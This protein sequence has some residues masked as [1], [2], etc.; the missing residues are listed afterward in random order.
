MTE[1]AHPPVA[2]NGQPPAT[3]A[4]LD[5][6]S[7]SSGYLPIAEHGV[8]GDLHSAA[9]VGTDGTIDWYCPERFDRPSVF[10]AL[11]DRRSGGFYRIAPTDPQIVAKQLYLPDTAVLI[12]RFL[13]PAGVSEIQDFMPVDGTD[14]RLIRRVV[15]L[16][17]QVQ[18]GLQ[19]EPRFDYGRLEPTLDLVAGGAVFRAPGHALTLATPITLNQA[20]AGATANF[21]VGAGETRTFVLDGTEQPRQLSESEAERLMHETAAFWRDWLAQSSYQGRWREMVDRSALTLKLLSYQPSGAVVAAATTS[22]P[23]QMGGKR[24]WDYR[25]AWVRDFAFS[26]FALTRLGFTLEA[27]AFN[28]FC[29]VVSKVAAPDNSD[30]PL[31]VM[32]RIDAASDLG[33]QEL[34]HLEGYRGSGPVRIGNGA[35]TQLQLDIYGELFN[36]I[37]IAERHAATGRGELLAYDDWRS[38]AS[39]IDWLCG[40]WDGPDEGIWETRAGRKRFTYSRLMSWVAIDRAIRIA[41]NRALP[42]DLARWIATRDEIFAWIMER[43]WSERRQAF[44]Q[45]E[46]TD[47]LDASLLLMPL[48]RFIAPTDPRWLSTLDAIGAELVADSLVRRYDPGASPDGLDGDEGTFSVCSFWYV[49]CLALAGRLEQAQLAF[50]KMLT[51]ANHLGLY[52]E[53]IGPTG[54][55]LGNFPQALTHLGLIS[56]GTA[57]DRALTAHRAKP[58]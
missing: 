39:L 57:L 16:R 54:E 43:G 24:N 4:R 32:Y 8:I 36:A 29:R 34:N 50:G 14:R 48:V 18:F 31:Q 26:I 21:Q 55:Q 28:A 49:E 44:V 41:R 17:G 27:K 7:A 22:L 11:L 38:L 15:G 33:E 45:S 30:S 46:D 53:E 13:S 51:Y 35:A 3:V 52:A 23:E 25:Y 42:A 10:A 37:Y 2:T 12:T 6:G 5:S 40:H 20:G 56:A 19:I 58:R 1:S 47:V 9:L